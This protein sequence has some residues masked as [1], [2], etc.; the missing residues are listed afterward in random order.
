MDGNGGNGGDISNV[1]KGMEGVDV[2]NSARRVRGKKGGEVK[3]GS[4]GWI[5]KKKEQMEAKGKV[6]KSNSKYTGR[7]RKIT[8]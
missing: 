3:K 1:V 2:D 6:V 5:M 7:K 8:W 4:K